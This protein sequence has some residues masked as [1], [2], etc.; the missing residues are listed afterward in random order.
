MLGAIFTYHIILTI[1][2]GAMFDELFDYLQVSL[3]CCPL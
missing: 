3:G 2:I 1:D